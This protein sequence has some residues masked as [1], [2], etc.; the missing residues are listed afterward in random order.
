MSERGKK[1]HTVHGMT[2]ATA[3]DAES[4]ETC[5]Q[6]LSWALAKVAPGPVYRSEALVSDIICLELDARRE[7]WTYFATWPGGSRG[8]VMKRVTS[9]ESDDED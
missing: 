2:V 1:V 6:A 7:A 5:C 3:S 4:S 8:L 9:S